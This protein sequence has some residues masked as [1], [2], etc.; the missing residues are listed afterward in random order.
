MG[1]RRLDVAYV[2]RSLGEAVSLAVKAVRGA[3]APWGIAEEAGWAIR[4]LGRAGLPGVEALANTLEAGDLSPLSLG[5]SIADRRAV[6]DVIGPVPEPL[7]VIPFLS[8]A[9]PEGQALTLDAGET[10]ARVWSDGAEPLPPARELRVIDV[11]PAPEP[12]APVT[13]I[14][15]PAEAWALLESFA[16]R[17]YAPATEQS[18]QSGA[19]AGLTD[20]D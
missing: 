16:H 4:W 19:G 20:N 12:P 3:G 7:L 17:T 5:I 11:C 15:A 18:R 13:R 6:P 9:V 8:R 10:T 2:T 1:A 14:D